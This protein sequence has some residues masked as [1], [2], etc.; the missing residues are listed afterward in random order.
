MQREDKTRRTGPEGSALTCMFVAPGVGIEPTTCGLT[1]HRN[2]SWV[3]TW[4]AS[5]RGF[6]PVCLAGIPVPVRLCAFCAMRCAMSRQ[7]KRFYSNFTPVPSQLEIL[8]PGRVGVSSCADR[9]KASLPQGCS[10]R[11]Y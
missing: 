4:T 9:T 3:S 8:Q 10:S 2:L 1:D 6:R 5:A 7:T 11:V